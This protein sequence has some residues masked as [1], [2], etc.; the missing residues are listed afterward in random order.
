MGSQWLEDG[1]S[2]YEL[3]QLERIIV[4]TLVGVVLAGVAIR[5]FG[6][7]ARP[8]TPAPAP[9]P[10]PFQPLRY[11]EDWSYLENASRRSEW[12]DRLKYIPLND[13]GWYLS[14]GGESR[15]RYEY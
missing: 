3:R 5:G 4:C 13:N 10:P 15:T 11:E 2:V 8:A 14:L 1:I 9:T 12:L 7:T 6:Q